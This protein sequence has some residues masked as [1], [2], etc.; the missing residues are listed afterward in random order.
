MKY[1]IAIGAQKFEVEI[2]EIK[3]GIARVNVNGEPLEVLI[4]NYHEVAPGPAPLQMAPMRVATPAAPVATAAAAPKVPEPARAAAPAAVATPRPAAAA[5]DPAP[6]RAVGKGEIVA[7]IP[8]RILDVKV[9]AGDRVSAG[10]TVAIMEAMKMENNIV[11]PVAG[12]V[13]EILVQKD[14]QVAFGQRIMVIA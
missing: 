13:Q 14:S 4:E 1:K 2:G 12:T 10:Q 6:K 11:S 8:G 3:E 5:A 9:Q 7:P